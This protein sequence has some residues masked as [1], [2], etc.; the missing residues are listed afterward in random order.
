MLCMDKTLFNGIKEDRRTV[1]NSRLTHVFCRAEALEAGRG[2][3]VFKT[4][5]DVKEIRV[6]YYKPS[7][8]SDTSQI[9]FVM[10]G[11]KRNG[12]TYRDQWITHAKKGNFLLLVPEFSKKNYPGSAGY[13]LGNMFCPSRDRSDKESWCFSVIENLFDHVKA[14]TSFK[15]SAYSI[16]GHS[17]GAQFVHRFVM[18]MSHARIQTAIAA[19]AGWYTMPTDTVDFPYGLKNSGL[20]MEDLSDSFAKTLIILLGAKDTNHIHLRETPEAMAQ[21]EHRFSRGH[22]FYETAME[23]AKGQ[24]T[25]LEWRLEI[26]PNVGHCNSQMAG[27]AANLLSRNFAQPSGTPDRQ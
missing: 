21:G 3:F 18:F 22:R 16:Y 14:I 11:M 20:E 8:F 27:H 12:K 10:H 24:K 1:R 23:S 4:P 13:N 2:N 9:I 17:A 15:A 19:N 6:W 26:V 5:N 7:T 25:R